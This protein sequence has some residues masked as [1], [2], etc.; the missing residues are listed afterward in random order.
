MLL[1]YFNTSINNLI[2]ILKNYIR[3]VFTSLNFVNLTIVIA[4]FMTPFDISMFSILRTKIPT[5][6]FYLLKIG[7]FNPL[8]HVFKFK[9]INVFIA[10]LNTSFDVNNF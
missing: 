7:I 4:P 2:I 6:F 1:H 3:Y 8:L 10:T 5:N 9:I